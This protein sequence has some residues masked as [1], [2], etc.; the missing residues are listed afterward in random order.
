MSSTAGDHFKGIEL[1]AAVQALHDQLVAAAAGSA[2]RGIRFDVGDIE[3]EFAFELRRETKT[4]GKVKAWVVEGGAEHTRTG[5]TAHRVTF[6]LTPRDAVTG[7][8]S[9]IGHTDLGDV[10]DFGPPAP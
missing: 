5:A 4:G 6:S 8:R 9:Q 3:V 7:R 1:N 2:T 10:D